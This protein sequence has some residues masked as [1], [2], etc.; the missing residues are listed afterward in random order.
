MSVKMATAPPSTAIVLRKVLTGGRFKYFLVV[1]M[2]DFL[3][4]YC[5]EKLMTIC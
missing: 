5:M 4:F 3:L 1:L 2:R